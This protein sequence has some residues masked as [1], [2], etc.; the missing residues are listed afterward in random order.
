MRGLAVKNYK[1]L[2]PP[3]IPLGN[4]R[5]LF[6]LLL[7]LLLTTSF[8]PHLFS[9]ENWMLSLLNIT[10]LFPR[11]FLSPREAFQLYWACILYACWVLTFVLL[12][13]WSYFVGAFECLPLLRPLIFSSTDPVVSIEFWP[14]YD[15]AWN[16][17]LSL[18]LFAVL[19][20]DTPC[21]NLCDNRP[22]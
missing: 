4:N 14:F 19:R 7:C 17:T 13:P 10:C 6:Y 18:C 5:E 15:W 22:N 11:L 21:T 16:S 1:L 12:M 2:P 20:L 9:K 8:F 3:P